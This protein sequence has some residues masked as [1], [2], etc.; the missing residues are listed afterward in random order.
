MLASPNRVSSSGTLPSA[1]C[2]P[3]ASR[4]PRARK[5]AMIPRSCGNNFLNLCTLCG[6]RREVLL[7]SRVHGTSKLLVCCYVLLRMLGSRGESWQPPGGSWSVFRA[8]E[9][10]LSSNQE[11]PRISEHHEGLWKNHAI[12]QQGGTYAQMYENCDCWIQNGAQMKPNAG[13]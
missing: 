9:D 6:L 5:L 3:S 12:P 11:S 7:P 2:V 1:T 8:S 10:L 4:H 13:H